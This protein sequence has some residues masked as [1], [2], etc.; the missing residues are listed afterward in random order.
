MDFSTEKIMPFFKKATEKFGRDFAYSKTHFENGTLLM[1]KL[2]FDSFVMVSNVCSDKYLMTIM[3]GDGLLNI[4]ILVTTPEEM[5]E[6]MEKYMPFIEALEDFDEGV[7]E[8]CDCND[9]DEDCEFC[10]DCDEPVS[11]TVNINVEAI[12][13]AFEELLNLPSDWKPTFFD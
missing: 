2:G 9:C 13:A 7:C 6:Y 1:Q 12:D 4:D 10:Y 11:Y 5:V 3:I 8:N